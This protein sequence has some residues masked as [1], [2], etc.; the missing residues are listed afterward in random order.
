MPAPLTVIKVFLKRAS[1]FDVEEGLCI[2]TVLY[3]LATIQKKKKKSISTLKHSII[4]NRF[5]S[6]Q[7]NK[8]KSQTC[9]D[10]SNHVVI[11]EKT[12][13]NKKQ[14]KKKKTT[15]NQNPYPKKT[16]Q[17]KKKKT[18][19]PKRTRS[20]GKIKRFTRRGRPLFLNDIIR[21]RKIPNK[22]KQTIKK[23]YTREHSIISNR[24]L[25]IQSNKQNSQTC[26]TGI[27]ASSQVISKKKKKR[28][29]T[30]P[31]PPPPPKEK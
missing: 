31:P 30:P 18:K 13:Q 7:S 14:T 17:K 26:Q 10:P 4:S 28:K 2:S 5:L 12:K 15:K 22:A 29:Q 9:T 23:K 24:Y 20:L 27:D 1:D 11:K 3:I 16:K 19:K 25:Y 6:L 8:Q 21:R